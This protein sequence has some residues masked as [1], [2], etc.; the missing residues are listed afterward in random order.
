M[1]SGDDQWQLVSLHGWGRTECLRMMLHLAGKTY[2]DQRLTLGA[3][4]DFKEKEGLDP[5]TKLPLFMNMDTGLILF[6]A[7]EIGRYLAHELGFYGDT[8]EER[9]SIEGIISEVEPLHENVA[10]LVRDT[11][12]RNYDLRKIH[13]NE[14]RE[15]LLN[16]TLERLAQQLGSR[17]FFVG[18]KMSWADV[19]VAEILLRFSNLFDSY[20]LCTYP[21]LKAHV[22]SV[23]R[24]PLLRTYV[25]LRPHSVF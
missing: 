17:T 7:N 20:F 5:G 15:S 2:I 25:A 11:L 14:F 24:S 21:T 9:T 3:W 8:D 18:T 16:P 4:R 23:E 1:S 12:A 19:A 22:T 10:P 6:G 13:W